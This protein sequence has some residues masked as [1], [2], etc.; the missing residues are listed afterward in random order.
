MRMRCPVCHTEAS[1]WAWS[2]CEAARERAL[3]MVARVRAM[4]RR[5]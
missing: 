4:L 3:E 5:L 1:L 2:E